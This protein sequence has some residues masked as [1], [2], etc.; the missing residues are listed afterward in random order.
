MNGAGKRRFYDYARYVALSSFLLHGG[1]VLV[2]GPPVYMVCTAV[3]RSGA[4]GYLVVATRGPRMTTY[5]G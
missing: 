1:A 5:Q 2:Y 3:E 4:F